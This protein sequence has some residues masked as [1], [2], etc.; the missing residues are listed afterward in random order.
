MDDERI[1]EWL[2]KLASS[3]PAPGGG[4]AAALEVA[5]GAALVEMLA[6]LTIG[7]P[8]YAEHDETMGSVRDRAAVLRGEATA[9]A[10]EDAAAYTSV[11]AAYR[12]PKQSDAETAVRT[13]AIQAALAL[14]ADVPRR[15]A[16][17]ASEVLDLAERIVP[18]ANVNVISDGAAAAAAARA[19]LQT[20]LLNIYANRASIADEALR[21]ELAAATRAIEADLV[22]ADEV[23]ASVRERSAG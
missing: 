4:A 8:A 10:A 14:A 21:D 11:I 22:R 3:A 2:G 23:V 18:I 16:A 9:L 12:L 20:A 17:A 1:G 7:K 6:S 15:T 13:A 19:A 5:M